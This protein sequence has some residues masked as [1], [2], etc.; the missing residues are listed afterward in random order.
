[1]VDAPASNPIASRGYLALVLDFIFSGIVRVMS[2]TTRFEGAGRFTAINRN[3]DKA[4]LSFGLIQWAQKP[5]RLN[6]LLRAFQQQQPQNFVRIFGG[7]D[8]ALAQALIAHTAKPGGGVDS[9]GR[10]TDPR[11]DLVSEPWVSRFHQAA[12]DR[13]LQRVQVN[14]ALSAFRV[15][16][17]RL[18]AFAPPIR[19]ERGVAFMLDLANQHGNG[20]AKSIF[21]KVQKPGLSE[22]ELLKAIQE[23]SVARVRAQFGEGNEVVSTRNRRE[24]F[25]TSPLLLGAPFNP[26]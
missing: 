18:Q 17:Q 19:S 9:Q 11:F 5:G 8:A 14:L 20:G 10:T 16:F 6:E 1:M 13:N 2:L 26:A 3:T 4:G 24:A 15:S 25:R 21:T 22:A 23:E 12:L 7:G